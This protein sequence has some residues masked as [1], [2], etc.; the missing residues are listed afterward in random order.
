MHSR[1]WVPS[2]PPAV[3]AAH[4][5]RRRRRP[6][7]ALGPR[8][9]E[10]ADAPRRGSPP[11]GRPPPPGPSVGSTCWRLTMSVTCEPERRE[12]VHELDAGDARADHHEVLGQLGRRVGV[13]ASSAPARRR[14]R[15]TRGCGA[16]SRCDSSTASAVELGDRPRPCRPRPRGGPSAGPCPAAMRTPWLSSRSAHRR[17]EAV[18]DL[19][20]ALP[21]RLEVDLGLDLASSPMPLD[22]PGERHGAA[23]WRSSPWTG[24]SPTGGRR[25]R[26][27]PSR[28]A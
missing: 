17:L 3:V 11:R 6:V 2:H 10:Q 24:C 4:R 20:V 25:R 5:P 23:A 26:R 18:L 15:P 9:L 8:P 13:A 27:R 14:A 16:G 12:H 19:D 1:A 7:D 21:Q 28:P 22:A